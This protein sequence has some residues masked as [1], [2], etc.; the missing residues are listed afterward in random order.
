M[1]VRPPLALA[2]PLSLFLFA[3]G[4]IAF[5]LSLDVERMIGDD[6]GYDPGS[7]IVPLTVALI[8]AVTM[9]WEA[10]KARHGATAS[11]EHGGEAGVEPAPRLLALHV[12]LAVAFVVLFRP[13][14]FI[15]ASTLLLYGLTLLNLRHVTH[16][17]GM[18]GGL[19][20]LAGLAVALAYATA[21]YSLARGTIRAGFWLA[22]E[23]GATL[24]REPNAQA[25]CVALALA[26]AML[27]AG[28]ALRRLIADPQ[29]RLLIQV[30]VGA[31]MAVYVVFRLLFLVQLPAG[32]LSW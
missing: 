4:Y 21:L 3:L 29:R 13:L 14:G 6:A 23:H 12:A 10:L 17:I 24:A 7:R 22:R 27:L 30:S 9:L 2:L 11:A 18:L 32:L 31:T 26:L 25:L 1:P 5:T 19:A 8:L 20:G 28:Q 15:L 16:R